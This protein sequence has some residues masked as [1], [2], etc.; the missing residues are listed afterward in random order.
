MG[1]ALIAINLGPGDSKFPW[2]CAHVTPHAPSLLWDS[3]SHILC[4]FL[5]RQ[6]AHGLGSQI[7]FDSHICSIANGLNAQ[8]KSLDKT[9]PH[10]AF[11]FIQQKGVSSLS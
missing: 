3:I 6:N 7:A 8:M 2:I 5:F 1:P 4:L 10:F 9:N 11:I